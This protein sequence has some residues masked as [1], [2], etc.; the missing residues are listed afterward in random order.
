[1]CEG[2]YLMNQKEAQLGKTMALIASLGTVGS[3]IVG[4]VLIGPS[5]IGYNINYG[6]V[7][8]IV[9][10][11]QGFGFV[12]TIALCMKLFNAEE[13]PYFRIISSVAFV[14]ASIQLTGALS[15]TATYNA[16]F[17]SIFNASEVGAIVGVGTF[18]S[19]IIYGIWA[20]SL[21]SS[22]EEN[23]LSSW[24]KMAGQGAAYLIFLVQAGSFFGFIPAGAFVAVFV[25]GGV[26]LYPLF[27]Y[28]ISNAF[29]SKI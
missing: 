15:A 9:S 28:S 2:G 17:D 24:G 8:D 11:V 20:L 7:S 3:F 29:A 5:N 19:F 21:I 4:A 14:A 18:V 23:L 16:V 1:M 12:F 10:F 27:V 22:D 6:A 13:N 25:L 26:I